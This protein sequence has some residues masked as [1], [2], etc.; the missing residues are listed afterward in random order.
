M[1]IWLAAAAV[2]IAIQALPAQAD[3][4]P[5]SGAPLPPK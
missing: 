2:S 3:R 5:L 1:R 4:D